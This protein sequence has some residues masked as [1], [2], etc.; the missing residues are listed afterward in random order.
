MADEDGPMTVEAS[1]RTVVSAIERSH[2]QALFGFA[3][4]LGVEHETAEDVVQDALLRLYDELVNGKRVD[5]PRAWIFTV[6]YRLTMDEYR[7]RRSAARLP[8]RMGAIPAPIDP[9]AH[10]E[11]ALVWA[12]VDR[13]PQRQRDVLYLRYRADLPF[14]IVGRVMGITPSAARS[15]ATQALT[16][17]RDRLVRGADE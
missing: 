15:H 5:D 2:G 6:T 4:R 14:E 8:G 10:S 11:R 1:A 7:R 17:L 12:E 3:L 13:L 9:V 16:R